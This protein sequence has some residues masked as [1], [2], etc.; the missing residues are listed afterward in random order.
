MSKDNVYD[1]F[2]R[3][4]ISELT[5]EN[6]RL[7]DGGRYVGVL[8]KGSAI[9]VREKV[10]QLHQ[11][12]AQIDALLQEF[13]D[14]HESYAHELGGALAVLGTPIEEFDPERHDFFVDSAGHCWI[15]D[16]H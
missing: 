2:S 7:A 16:A 8:P 4:K 5:D 14:L 3:R 13:N 6:D 10:G 15:V 1:L 11:K 12:K 9:G